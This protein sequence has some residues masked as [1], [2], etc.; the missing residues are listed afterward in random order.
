[1]GVD[2][3]PTPPN[4]EVRKLGPCIWCWEL[5]PDHTPDGK[6]GGCPEFVKPDMR[7]FKQARVTQTRQRATEQQI[8]ASKQAKYGRIQTARSPA[9]QK[10]HEASYGA[11][12]KQRSRDLAKAAKTAF[13][14]HREE[15]TRPLVAAGADGQFTPVQRVS[16]VYLGAT[17]WCFDEDP[18]NRGHPHPSKAFF[19]ISIAEHV[20]P[21]TTYVQADTLMH[22][23][24]ASVYIVDP[25][26][27]KSTKAEDHRAHLDLLFTV[28]S[29]PLVEVDGGYNG[30]RAW[31]IEYRAGGATRARMRME[32]AAG[33]S[34]ESGEER[35]SDMDF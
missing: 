8:A 7:D 25:D 24:E 26:F 11:V 35:E 3:Q 32:A 6:P 10:V 17:L 12:Y 34:D 9:E 14:T 33:E 22:V 20:R 27:K 18:Q 4:P 16:I 1:M 23:P 19:A 29:Q 31:R 2:R 15:V 21:G 30:E 28:D 13:D 5:E